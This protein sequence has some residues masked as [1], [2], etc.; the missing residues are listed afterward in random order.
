LVKGIVINAQGVE[1]DPQDV[2]LVDTYLFPTILGAGN[3]RLVPVEAVAGVLQIKSR[4]T[5]SSIRHA[6]HNLASAKRLLSREPRYGYTPA[7]ST[8]P[9]IET[10]VATFFGG[11][12]FLSRRAAR[13]SVMDAYAKAVMEVEKRER[14]D[15]LCIVDDLSI[16]WGN[17]SE[18][19]EPHFAFRGEQ[20]E[21]PLCLLADKDSILFFYLSLIQHLANWIPSS[22]PWLEYVFGSNTSISR[23]F[24]FQYQYWQ[25]EG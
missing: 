19:P 16:L 8:T 18:G 13:K 1:S 21:A 14:S 3:T 23:P 22:A 11:A 4:A 2:I 12:I 20:A 7:G 5:P 24:E 25:D 15:A 10:T 6:V 17:P 9:C